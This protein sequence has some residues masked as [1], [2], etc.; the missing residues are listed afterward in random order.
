MA[1]IYKDKQLNGPIH[2]KF[3]SP[4]L[5]SLYLLAKLVQWKWPDVCGE[6]VHVVIMGGL[7]LEIALWNT[8]GDVLEERLHTSLE[9]DMP[10]S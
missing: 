9:S 6:L 10:T 5:I 4:P 8:L 1:W 7:H 3:Q 2:G